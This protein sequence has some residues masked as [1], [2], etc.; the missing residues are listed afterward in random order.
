MA[1][2]PRAASLGVQAEAAMASWY[3]AQG[4]EILA[5]NWRT[6][7]GEID[8]VAVLDD[9]VVFVEVKARSS[10][11]FGTGLDA[12]TPAKMARLHRLGRAFLREHA[13]AG[14]TM[15]VDVASWVD[16]KWD[17]VQGVD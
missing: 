10:A 12:I 17:V 3:S 8:I 15:R 13:L 9:V 4:Y 7:G 11:R 6:K 16:G 14:R 2:T 5:R 1:K